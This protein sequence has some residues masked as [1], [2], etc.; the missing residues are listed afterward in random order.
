[1]TQTQQQ[2]MFW[3]HV[4]VFVILK[5]TSVL[6]PFDSFRPDSN[7]SSELDS[8]SGRFYKRVKDYATVSSPQKVIN[9][10]SWIRNELVSDRNEH[11]KIHCSKHFRNTIYGIWNHTLNSYLTYKNANEFKII[12]IKYSII[13]SIT[14]I[15]TGTGNTMNSMVATENDKNQK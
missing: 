5:S 8:S 11:T 12:T 3:L 13:C 10:N 1:M 7:Q 14:I 2:L 4:L 15:T 6:A 9:S